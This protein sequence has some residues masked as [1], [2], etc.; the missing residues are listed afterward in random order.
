MSLTNDK[1]IEKCTGQLEWQAHVCTNEMREWQC[2][3]KIWRENKDGWQKLIP[4]S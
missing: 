1:M 4:G 3:M 2:A